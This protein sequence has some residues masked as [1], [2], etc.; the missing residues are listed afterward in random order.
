MNT[1]AAINKQENGQVR[2]S[3]CAVLHTVVKPVTDSDSMCSQIQA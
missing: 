1:P 3:S 2:L